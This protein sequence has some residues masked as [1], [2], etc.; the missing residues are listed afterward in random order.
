MNSKFT[1][2]AQN[3]LTFALNSARELGHTYIGSEHILLGLSAKKDSV[4]SK[5]L[6][7]K[8]GSYDKFL[9]SVIDVSGKGEPSSVG[10]EDMTPCVKRI[11][12]EASA[13]SIRYGQNY[14]GTEHLLLSLLQEKNSVSSRILEVCQI[15]AEDLKTDIETFLGG[16]SERSKANQKSNKSDQKKNS[17]LLGFGKDLTAEAKLGKLDPII[18]RDAES[19]RIIQ[20]LSRRIKNNPCLIGESGVG[21]T[22]VV[23]GIAQRIASGNVPDSLKDK[24]IITLDIPS[25]IAGAKYRGEFE[26]RLKNVIKEVSERP[27]IILFIDEIHTITGAG[28]AEGALDAANILKPALS[29]G[30]M[31]VIGATTLE[32]YRRHIEK[33]AALERRFQSVMISEPTPED[34]LKI[35]FGLRNTYEAFHKIKISDDA[36]R[37]SVELSRRYISD[38]FLPDKAIDLLDET[39]ARLRTEKSTE[40]LIVKS[41]GSELESLKNEKEEAIAT[42]DFELAATLRD[43]ESRLRVEYERRKSEWQKENDE[44]N[45]VLVTADDIA[46][47]LCR[48]TGIP[49]GELTKDESERLLLMETRLKEKII[50]QDHA[51]SAV[52]RAILR[53]RTGLSD[54]DKPSGSFIFTGP[55]GVGKSA[56][57]MYLAEEVFGDRS[58]FIR[59]DMSEYTEKHSVSKLIGAPPGYIGYNEGGVLVNKIRRHPYSLI[60]FDEIEKAH[61]DIFN[62][63]L[64]ILDGGRLT[65]SQGQNCDFRNTVIIMTSNL[66]G[67]EASSGRLGFSDSYSSSVAENEKRVMSVLKS[68]FRP[69]FLNRID[70]IVVFSKLTLENASRI[71]SIML[72]EISFRAKALGV[73]LDFDESAKDLIIENGFDEQY[74]ARHLKRA[75][76]LLVEDA[77]SLEYLGKRIASGDSVTAHAKNGK[78]SF[79]VNKKAS[80]GDV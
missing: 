47:T 19:T 71:A 13:A 30:E 23:E 48:Q 59:L 70:E 12:E 36:L 79:F 17:T 20:I 68:T 51:V 10:A 28:A 27:E 57:A 80:V 2:K 40:P 54:P 14:I 24:I 78:I 8:G 61:P 35:L 62:V 49:V 64:Q 4:S 41:A 29:R 15:S 56:L 26:E 1:Q 65:D 32:E 43:K 76:S 72:S 46:L 69:E 25:M 45:T 31:R 39:A 16:V 42:Q 55:T 34:T 60:L 22:A 77:F 7:A 53:S 74:G 75:I 3:T 52:T 5:M 50:G 9:N 58:A 33:D 11:I 37:V 18:G 38:R 21:K 73:E 67:K 44:D 63:L 6:A 66:G